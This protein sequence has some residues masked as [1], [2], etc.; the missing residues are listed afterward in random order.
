MLE[1]Y[2]VSDEGMTEVLIG[3]AGLAAV[4][5]LIS[6]MNKQVDDGIASISTVSSKPNDE[7]KKIKVPKIYLESGYEE[8]LF[9]CRTLSITYLEAL[10]GEAKDFKNSKLDDKALD[11]MAKI[12]DT[13]YVNFIKEADKTLVK[14][15]RHQ[16]NELDTSVA[17]HLFKI[18]KLHEDDELVETTLGKA[19]HVLTKFTRGKWVPYDSEKA[20][21]T[22]ESGFKRV[23]TN[24]S[25]G[26]R[27]SAAVKRIL[28]ISTQLDS[29]VLLG[30]KVNGKVVKENK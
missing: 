23:D 18:R 13:L 14:F 29:I 1:K 25:S 7:Q 5:L 11:K 15:S 19:W 22:I 16:Q 6:K 21:D 8:W 2:E 4:A 24:T 28:R 10:T 3:I 9:K 27:I 12:L 20:L 30:L 17:D 26:H